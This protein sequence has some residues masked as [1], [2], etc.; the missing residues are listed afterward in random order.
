MVTAAANRLYALTPIV[1]VSF[2]FPGIDVA[3]LEI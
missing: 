3:H 2:F 1:L